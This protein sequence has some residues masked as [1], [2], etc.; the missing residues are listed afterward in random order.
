GWN[1]YLVI[2]W[3]GQVPSEDRVS[4]ERQ[5]EDGEFNFTLERLKLRST[6]SNFLTLAK[7]NPPPSFPLII[8]YFF[9]NTYFAYTAWKYTRSINLDDR[10]AN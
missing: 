5:T 1:R 3:T 8:V 4:F 10:A 2:N 9:W 7:S 6:Q